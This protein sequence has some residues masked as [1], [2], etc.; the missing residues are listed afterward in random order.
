[1]ARASA[2]AILHIDLARLL[3][4]STTALRAAGPGKLGAGAIAAPAPFPRTFPYTA[5]ELVAGSGVRSLLAAAIPLA[6]VPVRRDVIR[7]SARQA[8]DA[9]LLVIVGRTETAGL[10]HLNACGSRVARSHARNILLLIH[11]PNVIDRGLLPAV[12]PAMKPEPGR[13]DTAFGLLTGIGFALPSMIVA[14]ALAQVAGTRQRRAII[15]VC[16]TSGR[17]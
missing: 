14:M 12:A 8:I 16:A 11:I 4:R 6:A 17:R 13:S 5:I 2:R 15:A 10:G 7:R 1:M 3:S 9:V